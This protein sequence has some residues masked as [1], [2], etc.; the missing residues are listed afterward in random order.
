[1]QQAATITAGTDGSYEMFDY[2]ISLR[3]GIMD[4]W[5]GIIGAMKTSGKSECLTTHLLRYNPRANTDVT[6]AILQPYVQSIFEL[7]NSI[8][9]DANRSEALMR[10]SMGV[11]G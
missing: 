9:N 2:V 4:A 1:M 3:E 8:A 5:G 6:A 7:L 11:I 10:A